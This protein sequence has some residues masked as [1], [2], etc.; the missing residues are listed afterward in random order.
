MEEQV[1]M[2][3]SAPL[4]IQ[5][6]HGQAPDPP[7]QLVNHASVPKTPMI[8]KLNKMDCYGVKLP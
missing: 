6:K 7:L 4:T 5:V 3:S 8:I 2:E 1:A